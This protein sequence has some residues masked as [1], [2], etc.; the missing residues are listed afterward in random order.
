MVTNPSKSVVFSI[1][2]VQPTTLLTSAIDRLRHKAWD[3]EGL[4]VSPHA[5]SDPNNPASQSE[6]ACP[7]TFL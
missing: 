5:I 3:K 2:S 4:Q 7:D 1:Y 6:G